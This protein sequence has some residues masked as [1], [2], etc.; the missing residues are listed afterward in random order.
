MVVFISIPDE[1]TVAF[2]KCTHFYN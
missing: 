1:F 2:W